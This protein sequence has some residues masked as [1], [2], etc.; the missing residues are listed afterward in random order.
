MKVSATTSYNVTTPAGRAIDHVLTNTCLAY[1]IGNGLEVKEH[2]KGGRTLE[3]DYRFDDILA[4]GEFHLLVL[5]ESLA[6]L[7]PVNLNLLF[8][9]IDAAHA[10][11][12]AEAVFIAA[13]FNIIAV[14]DG[15]AAAEVHG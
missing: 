2:S 7:T 12:V 8:A 3:V 4:G 14:N 13:G 5:I 15:R 1:A 6:G 11:V 10:K 9:G